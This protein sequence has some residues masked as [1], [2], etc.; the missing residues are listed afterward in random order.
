MKR[1]RKW[2]KNKSTNNNKR[3]I[4]INYIKNIQNQHNYGNRKSKNMVKK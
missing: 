1:N 4:K 3:Q 2:N